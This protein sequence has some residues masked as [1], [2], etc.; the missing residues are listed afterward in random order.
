MFVT[1]AV[2]FITGIV[3]WIVY[4]SGQGSGKIAY[5]GLIKHTWSE[6]H[7]YISLAFMGALVIHWALNLKLFRSMA[8]SIVNRK[9]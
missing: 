6:I 1:M 2:S 3:L 8:N 9:K 5:L 7:I 4:P